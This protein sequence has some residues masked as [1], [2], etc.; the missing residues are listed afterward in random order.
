MYPNQEDK[1]TQSENLIK[2][3]GQIKLLLLLNYDLVF[4]R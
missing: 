3:E 4:N 1:R 2:V